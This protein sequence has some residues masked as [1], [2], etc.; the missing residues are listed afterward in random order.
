M[1]QIEFDFASPGG[2][3]GLSSDHV[4]GGPSLA[5]PTLFLFKSW[6]WAPWMN[7]HM[8]QKPQLFLMAFSGVTFNLDFD[9]LF[10]AEKLSNGLCIYFTQTS[11]SVQ[12]RYHI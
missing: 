4:P 6:D 7:C 10:I 5:V 2:L 11:S 12:S 1:S 8:T 9:F 3:S